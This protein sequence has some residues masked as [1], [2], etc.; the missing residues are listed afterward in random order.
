[1]PGCGLDETDHSYYRKV[2]GSCENDIESAGFT[3][4]RGCL[5]YLS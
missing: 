4:D 2:G 1:V 3:T 5:D